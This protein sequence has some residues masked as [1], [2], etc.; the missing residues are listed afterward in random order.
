MKV[1]GTDWT[2]ETAWFVLVTG[3]WWVV[4]WKTVGQ[5]GQEKLYDLYWWLNCGRCELKESGTDGTRET[6]W[7]VLVTEWWWVVNW[8]TLGQMGQEKLNDLYWSLNY[9]GWWAKTQ[10]GRWD[11]RNALEKLKI[12]T[13]LQLETQKGRGI[14]GHLGLDEMMKTKW[15]TGHKRLQ[16]QLPSAQ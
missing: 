13:K 12:H 10:W 16:F 6:A 1:S 11:R 3:W 2:R 5:I 9:G 7:F 15:R 4:K 8:K 14:L